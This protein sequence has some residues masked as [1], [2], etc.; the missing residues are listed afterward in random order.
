MRKQLF[1]A[2][3]LFTCIISNKMQAQTAAYSPVVITTF[4]LPFV[5]G[6]MGFKLDSLVMYY[7]DKGIRP[8]EM[9]KNFR[10]L[11]HAWGS[12]SSQV[13]FIYEIDK[14]ENLDKAET[15]VEELV[16]ASFKTKEEKELF[17]KRFGMAF[18]KHE[19]NIMS[20]FVKP[21]L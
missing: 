5:S 13:M 17:W 7:V 12:N 19:D 8:N 9:I 2:A 16:N 11:R 20:D 15:K 10:I 1:I 14:M 18:N 6:G 3:I 21:K 4:E